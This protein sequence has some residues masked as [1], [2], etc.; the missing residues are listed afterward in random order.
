MLTSRREFLMLFIVSLDLGPML[1]PVFPKFG[2]TIAFIAH[3]LGVVSILSFWL[4][5]VRSLC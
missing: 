3:V 5:Q 4:V 2:S 1:D